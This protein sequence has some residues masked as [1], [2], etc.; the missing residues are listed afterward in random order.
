MDAALVREI[1][2]E[3][4][5]AGIHDM[6]NVAYPLVAKAVQQRRENVRRSIKELMKRLDDARSAMAEAQDEF[7]KVE[8]RDERRQVR[9]Q[10]DSEIDGRRL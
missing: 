2:V 1:T 4:D 6:A 3:E 9:D 5:R 7:R 8:F 10:S